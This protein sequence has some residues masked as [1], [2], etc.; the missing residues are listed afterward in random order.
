[1]FKG[2]ESGNLGEGRNPNIGPTTPRDSFY[3][4]QVR[5]PNS[6]LLS[7]SSPKNIGSPAMSSTFYQDNSPPS[8]PSP[9]SPQVPPYSG[10]PQFPQNL[11]PQQQNYYGMEQWP[12]S[13]RHDAIYTVVGRILGPFWNTRLIRP[14]VLDGTKTTIVS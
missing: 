7:P 13:N 4:Q 3:Q 8:M 10:H 9:G 1:M 11:Q 14:A 5:S 12:Y 6:S 2:Y